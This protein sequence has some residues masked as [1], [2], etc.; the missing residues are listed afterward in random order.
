MGI[1]EIQGQETVFCMRP[2]SLVLAHTSGS[3][4]DF[5]ISFQVCSSS[6]RPPLFGRWPPHCLKKYATLSSAQQH[7]T[8]RTPDYSAG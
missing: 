5:G 3:V 6:K 8:R 7:G 1:V 4:G 2:T